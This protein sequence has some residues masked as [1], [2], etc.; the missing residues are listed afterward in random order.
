MPKGLKKPLSPGARLGQGCGGS[1]WGEERGMFGENG[2]M[3]LGRVDW[4]GA[5]MW[6][7]PYL[8]RASSLKEEGCRGRR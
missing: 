6:Q 4:R 3:V 2:E 5:W 8:F 1:Q 7:G